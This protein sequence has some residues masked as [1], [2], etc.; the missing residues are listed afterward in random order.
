MYALKWGVTSLFLFVCT[1][2]NT[3]NESHFSRKS[4]LETVEQRI[5]ESICSALLELKGCRKHAAIVDIAD[6]FF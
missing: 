1:I 6:L 5:D 2:S 3:Q 4:L